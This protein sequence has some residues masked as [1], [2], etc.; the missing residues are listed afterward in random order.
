MKKVLNIIFVT[1]GVVFLIILVYLFFFSPIK[2]NQLFGLGKTATSTEEI[3]DS[4]GSTTANTDK[5]PLLSPAQE[6][7]L[8]TFGI[9]P[10][11]LPT[12]ITPEMEQCFIA[13]LGSARVEAIKS[14][15]T[16]TAAEFY[17]ARSCF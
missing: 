12:Q 14:G 10:S 11:T 16:P 17:A 1:L 3:S 2:V 9:D 8:Q 13:K 7:T 15:S 5:N 4:N 6:K